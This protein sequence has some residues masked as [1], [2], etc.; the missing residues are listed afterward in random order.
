[1]LKGLLCN[2][3]AESNMNEIELPT[4]TTSAMLAAVEFLYT[5]R[6]VMQQLTWVSAFDTIHTSGYLL[7]DKLRDYVMTYLIKALRG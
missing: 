1:M 2:G 6:I 3:I 5:G 4:V 7:I